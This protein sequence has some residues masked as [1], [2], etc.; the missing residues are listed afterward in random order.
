MKEKVKI[1][2]LNENQMLK[3]DVWLE[4]QNKKAAELQK[5]GAPY[6]GA[7][8]GAVTYSFIPTSLGIIATVKHAVT[9]EE[10]DLTD[11]NSW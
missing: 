7:I 9:K 5:K 1:F 3:L 2:S 10:I 4:D 11:Y 6:Y 8:G